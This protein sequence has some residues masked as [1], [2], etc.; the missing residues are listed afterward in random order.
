MGIKCP[1]C[2]HENPDDTLYCGKCGTL[3]RSVRGTS[4]T[5]VGPDHRSGR[6]SEDTANLTETLETPK[7]ELTTGSTFAGRY[8]IIEE[9]GKGGMGKVYKANDTDIKEKVAIK[10][11]KP[12][13]ST[14]KKTI[15]RFQN[16]LKFARKIRHKNVCQ[17]FDLNREE[18]TYYITMEYVEG[19]NL[20][21]MIRMSGKLGIGTAISV[22]KQVCEGLV[23][24]HKL[25]VVHRDLKPSNIMIDREGI[26][27]IMDFGIARSLKEK[28]ITGAGVM[29]GTPEYMS[30]EQ[31]ESKE[32]DHRSDI[33]SLGII[34]YEMVIGR[35]PFE[36]DTPLSVAVKHKT[37]APQDPK[38]LN[39]QISEDL[40]KVILRC[41]EKDKEKRYQSADELRSELENIEKGIPTTEQI[42]PKSKP[43]TSQEVTVTFK[44]RWALVAIPM[45]IILAA[46]LAFL[47]FNKGK[48]PPP[49]RNPKIIVL[50]F[51]NLGT[52][53][54][55]YFATGIAEG[56]RY[57]LSVLHDLDVISG[58][59]AN[60]YKNTGKT[61]KQI[62]EE[63]NTDYILRGTVQW[64]KKEGGISRVRIRPSL[65]QTIDDT[66]KWSDEIDRDV[67]DI[68]T[69]ESEIAEQVTGQL[70]LILK[71]KEIQAIEVRPTGNDKAYQA[72]LR[73]IDY[74]GNSILQE[75]LQL[76]IQMFE[77]AVELDPEF[78][79]AYGYL[80][81][82][83]SYM[84]HQGYDRTEDRKLMAKE[85]VDRMLDLE[86]DLPETHSALGTF[87][88]W[89]SRDYDRALD[90]LS[91]AEK[92][93]PND[94][95]IKAMIGYI[96]RRQGDFYESINLLKKSLE[97][98]PQDLDV[99]FNIG[100]T[101]LALRNYPEAEH[102]F[103]KAISLD[104]MEVRGYI[105]L[106]LTYWLWSGESRRGGEIIERMPHYD[107]PL[108]DYARY[109]N[110]M[111]KGDYPAALEI[112]SKSTFEIMP[113]EMGF[114][115]KAELEG[116]AYTAMG[117]MALARVSYNSA[118]LLLEAEVKKSP[119]DP[120]IHSSLGLV[121]A[122]L[123]RKDD[124]IHEGSKA[125]EIYPVSLDALTGPAF[126]RNFAVILVRVEEYEKALDQIDYLL[127]IPFLFLSVTSLQKEVIWNPLRDHPRFKQI[128]EKYSE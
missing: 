118:R 81:K 30:P 56:I 96:R 28:G 95:G 16:E 29:I 2:Q 1:K 119:L 111:G 84:Y 91:I 52:A 14:D 83:H 20:K 58:D 109:Y 77:L 15:E 37:E 18:G 100:D 107:D 99:A 103:E 59:T 31:V 112:L 90:E 85:A 10:L 74:F 117:E 63:T 82:V 24:A 39:S 89:C 120:R 75:D 115:T 27:R 127:S 47:L 94:A 69:V 113:T 9:L 23:E 25:G 106:A 26:V 86:P 41:M 98:D 53:D 46:A 78:A 80:S 3:M 116:D 13:I 110:E 34:L 50:P 5:G 126:V 101:Y 92:G 61:T 36:G 67:R 33:Y 45:V 54:D 121:Y 64:D 7:E 76:A 35:V 8:Q 21:N 51:E 108:V 17:M 65:I 72:Y 102:Y 6:P 125:M 57:R 93:L 60:S 70:E 11:I 68:F 71:P 97:L 79:R 128:I 87:Y 48:E 73:G 40:S 55:E 12:E 123:G 43:I 4:P 88:Y 104:P 44:K 22:A 66:Q 122:A 32:T 42:V 38:E 114:F 19:E 124:A 105:F 49:Q 62:R